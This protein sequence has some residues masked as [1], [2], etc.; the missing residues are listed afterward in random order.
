[1]VGAGGPPAWGRATD[2]KA[3]GAKGVAC[4]SS[5]GFLAAV[6]VGAGS[7]LFGLHELDF[8]KSLEY[9]SV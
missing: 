5:A 1:M 6:G 7:G 9:V 4:P 8:R 3:G 2:L